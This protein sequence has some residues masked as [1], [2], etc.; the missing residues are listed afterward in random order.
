MVE[1]AGE[2]RWPKESVR[3]EVKPLFGPPPFLAG[4]DGLVASVE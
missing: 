2:L 3:R 1:I 4:G